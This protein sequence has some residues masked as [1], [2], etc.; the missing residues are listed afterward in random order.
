MVSSGQRSTSTGKSAQMTARARQPEV[1]PG[2]QSAQF[3]GMGFDC[4]PPLPIIL[5]PF[6]FL[7]KLNL[8]SVGLGIDSVPFR[9]GWELVEW[10]S[11]IDESRVEFDEN[12]CSEFVEIHEEL[13]VEDEQAEIL[14]LGLNQI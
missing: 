7:K 5:I 8:N 3:P 2:A 12:L 10:K 4:M 9:F 11:K 14:G 13:E 6:K 1:Y